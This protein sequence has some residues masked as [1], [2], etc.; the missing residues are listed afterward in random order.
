MSKNQIKEPPGPKV[1]Q[2]NIVYSINI[3]EKTAVVIGFDQK[4]E[5]IL[6]LLSCFLFE[7]QLYHHNKQDLYLLIHFL[8]PYNK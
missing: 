4:R 3:K 6:D 7:I 8:I 1:V 2:G 5:L